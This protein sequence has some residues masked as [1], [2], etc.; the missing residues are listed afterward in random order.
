VNK[1]LNK[2]LQICEG[3]LFLF[4]VTGILTLL[5]MNYTKYFVVCFV[6]FPF[7]LLG[8]RQGQALIDSLLKELPKAKEDSNQVNLLI[9]LSFAYYTINTDEGI[10]YGERSL[11]LSEKLGWKKG[12]EDANNCIGCNYFTRSD[13][14][15][16]L[17][18]W[19]KA[20]SIAEEINDKK[21]IA[22]KLNN[23]G[24]V[25]YQ[26]CDYPK[27]LEYYF[28]ALRINE[29]LGN[30]NNMA[31][32]LQNIGAV[33]E[34]EGNQS[35]AL[36]YY[37]QAKKINEGLRDTAGI[38]VTTLM[39][40]INYTSQKNYPEA[41]KYLSNSLKLYESIGDKSGIAT[42]SLSLANAM[43]Y[44]KDYY[45][46]LEYA[47]RG[48]KISQDLQD[49]NGIAGSY[50]DLG[51]CYTNIAELPAKTHNAAPYIRNAGGKTVGGKA[52]NLRIA[53]SFFDKEIALCKETG[54]L[55]RIQSGMLNRSEA[56]ARTGKYADALESYK[57]SIAIKDSVFNKEKN[58]KITNLEHQRELDLKE[59]QIKILAQDNHVKSLMEEKEKLANRILIGSIAMI[60]AIAFSGVMYFVRKQ[61]TERLIAN[62]KINTLLKEQE[63]RSV[64]NMLEVQ[65]EERKRIAADL[66][67]RLGSMLSTVKLYF[68]SVE[69]QVD[70]LK[71]QNKDQY[72]KA[73]SLLD[74]ACDEVR[75]ISH[76]LVSG[77]LIKFGLVSAVNQMKDT[78][79]NT[80]KIKMNVL[81][82]GMEARLDTS[83]E[84]SVYRIVQELMTNVLKHA[85]AT[86]VTIQ[87][88]KAGNNLNIVVEDNGV[89]FDVEAAMKK[90]GMGLKNLEVRVKKMNG[91][92]TFDSGKGR[93]TTTIIDIPV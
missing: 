7:I 92:I 84:I 1:A 73:T 44:S 54:N 33:Y 15:K 56:L 58:L 74:E 26:Q 28:K 2:L 63:L 59:S 22:G 52:A 57:Q 72:H 3:L 39:I 25:Y 20:Y 79:E 5:S 81:S 34:L 30:K 45:N 48:L 70:D 21:G 14:V 66:H 10:K 6:F 91:A 71:Q 17:D 86:E 9:D 11:A 87:L 27:T 90:E 85:R 65:E 68:N 37:Q 76:N 8:Q 24:N 53:L 4:Y 16:A 77:E 19:L 93:G 49:K 40:G 41:L 62:E 80:G 32:N 12:I 35:Q 31:K 88:N 43:I 67:D 78:I 75:K 82:F 89:G 38:A 60:L 42:N 61:K 13:Y 64:S 51:I 55:Y 50:E 46:A 36:G 83:V 47:Y 23:I 18:H 29:E 69:E